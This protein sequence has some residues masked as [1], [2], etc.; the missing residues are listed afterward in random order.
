M[1]ILIQIFQNSVYSE[2]LLGVK[3]EHKER[4]L[5]QFPEWGDAALFEFWEGEEGRMGCRWA[6]SP[7]NPLFF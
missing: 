4:N 5:D 6:K 7:L 3:R 2:Y 1:S